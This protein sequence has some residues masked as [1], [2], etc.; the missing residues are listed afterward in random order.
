MKYILILIFIISCASKEKRY[1]PSF[2][3]E[4][5]QFDYPYDVQTYKFSSQN[6]KLKM[7]YGDLGDHE[8]KKVAVL[9][10]GKNFSGYY[11]EQIAN[12][13]VDKGYRVII[14]DQ[15]G[16][17]KSSKPS[18]YQYSFQQLALNTF[19][20]LDDLQVEKFTLVGHSMGGMLAVHMTNM[21][22]RVN[23]LILV[24]PIGLEDYL[25]YVEYKDTDIF[26]KNELAQ[27]VDTFRDYQ[28]KHYYDGQWSEKYE[29]LL[30][31]FKG[32]R[33]GPDWEL[34]AWNNALT[35]SPIFTNPI[36]PE[37][38]RLQV[39][40]HLILGTRDRTAPGAGWMKPGINKKLGQYNKL[41]A[42]IKKLNPRKITVIEI[43]DLGHMPQFEDYER[44]SSHFFSLF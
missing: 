23:R 25:N 38:A 19:S 43:E 17:G 11:W 18:Y 14:P 42:E 29:R 31:P 2:D 21:S 44:F 22:S 26:Y 28:K 20:L 15:V 3:G 37:L 4:L 1:V 41:G 13:L 40:T 35:Y 7:A 12:D 27:T 5:T 24:N 30:T 10:H 39:E 33:N 32:W 6:Q 9:L 8:S 34:V 36:R 16:F